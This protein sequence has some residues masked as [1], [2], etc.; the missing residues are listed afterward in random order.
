METE[1]VC[2]VLF[3]LLQIRNPQINGPLGFFSYL[4]AIVSFFFSLFMIR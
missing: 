4:L 1:L 2:M 3:S